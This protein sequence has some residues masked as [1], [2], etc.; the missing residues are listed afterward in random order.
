MRPRPA[1]AT[2]ISKLCD[3]PIEAVTSGAIT[4][5]EAAQLSR[6]LEVHVQAIET[7]DIHE[8]LARLEAEAAKGGQ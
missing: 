4:P 6:L 7:H 3:R 2:T 8:R 5:S 1:H